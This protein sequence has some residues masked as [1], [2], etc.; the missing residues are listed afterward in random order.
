MGG[1]L[2]GPVDPSF[3]PLSG[4]LKIM[5]RRHNFS[6]VAARGTAGAG[7]RGGGASRRRAVAQRRLRARADDGE[8]GSYA[9]APGRGQP[10]AAGATLISEAPRSGPL[11]LG[12]VS[13][14]SSKNAR[15]KV[16]FELFC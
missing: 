10:A 8:R 16:F 11:S 14:K 4:R 9:A 3:H 2:S 15:F 1:S 6:F 12:P 13:A 5:V 7:R